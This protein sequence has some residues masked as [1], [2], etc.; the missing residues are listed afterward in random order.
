[1]GKLKKKELKQLAKDAE[2]NKIETNLN[3]RQEY[4]EVNQ[5]LRHYGNMRFAQLTIF[6]A[7]TGG[8]ITLVFTK[9]SSALQFNL[10]ISLEAMGI[11]TA[12]VFLLMENSSTMKWKGFKNRANELEIELN[13]QQQRKSPSPGNWNATRA[14]K[15]LYW[16]IV[17]FWLGAIAYQLYQKFCN[18]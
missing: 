5:N 8:L 15:L 4:T 6:I 10:K 7:L 16:S 18:C 14:I 3:L 1:M 12:G 11:F 13:Y 17:V 9:L 2:R